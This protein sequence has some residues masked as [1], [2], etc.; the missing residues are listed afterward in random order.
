MHIDYESDPARGMRKARVEKRWYK[1]RYIVYGIFGDVWLE[2]HKERDGITTAR[3]V[4]CIQKRR[5]K[6]FK[7][8][9][10]RELLAL[11][12]MSRVGDYKVNL[13]FMLVS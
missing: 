1:E 6:S 4:K 12:K 5:I 10:K 3:A 13:R 9:L 2:V 11:A 7:I 8:D